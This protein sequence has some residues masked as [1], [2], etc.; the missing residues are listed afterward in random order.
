MKWLT[1]ERFVQVVVF[2]LA[3]G[4]RMAWV[5][6]I[7]F[8]GGALFGPDAPSYD[9]LAI[10]LLEGKGLQKWDYQGLFTDPNKAILVRSFRPPLLP[11]L[12][13]GIYA[14]EGHD[15]AAARIVMALLGAATCVVVMRI[16]RRL[17]G[18]AAAL[19]AGVLAAVYPRLVYYSGS[20]VTETPYTL[21]LAITVAVLLGAQKAD[22]GLW[23]WPVAGALLGLATLCRSALL[24]FVPFACV[25]TLVVRPRKRRAAWEAALLAAGFV[26]AM[27]PWWGR[28]AAIHGRFVPAT[29]EGGFT[30]WVTNNDRADGGG[31]CFWP[32][33]R[34][35][36]D[37]LSEVEIDVRFRQMGCAWVRSHPGRFLRL[38]A[39]KFVR[40]WR[41]WPHAS[42][43]SVGV[44]AAAVAGATFTPVLLLALWGAVAAR[45]RWRDLLLLYLLFLYCTLLHVTLMA[46]TRYRLP[47]EPFLIVLAAYGL[48]ELWKLRASRSQ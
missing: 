29:T 17:S 10:S 45:R 36:F 23:R 28:N 40:F 41:L 11:V 9:Q 19:I 38:A 15:Y 5:G 42:E 7:Q 4:L 25:W 34:A 30:L 26:A 48:V 39:A 21:L 33:D 8:R 43:P 46:I 12:L 2:G 13:A 24:G 47:L 35:S 20:I 3:L 16:A 6:V 31:H 32:E 14:V 37:G 27:A 22:A 44:V 1:S 18:A